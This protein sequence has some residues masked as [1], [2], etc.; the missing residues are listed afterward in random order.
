MLVCYVQNRFT[1]FIICFLKIRLYDVD[2]IMA[3]GIKGDEFYHHAFDGTWRAEN[4]FTTYLPCLKQD[5][6]KQG[7]FTFTLK[8]YKKYKLDFLVGF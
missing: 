7:N 8:W 3:Q 5:N 2:A 4:F 6:A 1:Y